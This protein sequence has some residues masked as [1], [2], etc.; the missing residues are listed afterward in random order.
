MNQYLKESQIEEIKSSARIHDYMF[1]NNVLSD[2]TPDA[3][4]KFLIS[5]L[6]LSAG[7]LSQELKHREINDVSI[8]GE[9][10]QGA[11]PKTKRKHLKALKELDASLILLN[12]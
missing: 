9:I 2:E 4:L 1:K 3:V 8:R 6:L 11:D 5:D 10:F 7:L 12:R